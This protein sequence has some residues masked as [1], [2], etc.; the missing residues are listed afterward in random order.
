M[1][2]I[3]RQPWK[4]GGADCMVCSRTAGGLFMKH[5]GNPRD[6]GLVGKRITKKRLLPPSF[7]PRR[8]P[9]HTHTHT[10]AMPQEWDLLN[11]C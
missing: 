11:L 7:V 3:H 4:G 5:T 1:V 2:K 8:T 6:A 10:K 9:P